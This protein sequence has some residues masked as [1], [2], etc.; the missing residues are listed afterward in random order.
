MKGLML[1]FEII[2]LVSVISFS[3]SHVSVIV[4]FSSAVNADGSFLMSVTSSCACP[5][6]HCF[7]P[8]D[9][10][11]QPFLLSSTR[12]LLPGC[13]TLIDPCL[14]SHGGMQAITIYEAAS[15]VLLLLNTTHSFW[16]HLLVPSRLLSH[17][18]TSAF[19]IAAARFVV[20][21]AF[22]SIS[23]EV[24]L[25]PTPPS[26]RHTHLAIQPPYVNTNRC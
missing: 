26:Q 11:H 12:H 16:F 24:R 9:L 22:P 23:F 18:C 20:H 5:H 14:G 10:L 15:S 4:C 3:R 8:H 6:L 25:A 2:F 19:W 1:L 7:E 13:E 17:C 21:I